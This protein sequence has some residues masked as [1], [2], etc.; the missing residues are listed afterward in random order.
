MC[1]RD[2]FITYTRRK[3]CFE[4]NEIQ[5]KEISGIIQEEIFEK[6][7]EYDKNEIL[8]YLISKNN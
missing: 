5:I 7:E 8:K 6:C 4:C 1:I 2:R 3:I